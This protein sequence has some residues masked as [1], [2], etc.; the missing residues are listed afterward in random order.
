MQ[1]LDELR[2]ISF[3]PKVELWFKDECGVEGDPRPRRRWVQPGKQRM[4]LLGRSTFAR[5]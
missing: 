4:P 3:D 5:R 1:F 2:G